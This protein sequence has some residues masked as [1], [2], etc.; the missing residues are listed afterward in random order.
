M[1]PPE[2]SRDEAPSSEPSE[3][4]CPVCLRNNVPEAPFCAMCGAPLGPVANIDPIQQIRSEGFAFRSAVSSPP[5]AL[6]LAGTWLAMLPLAGSAFGM[7]LSGFPMSLFGFAM[8]MLSVGVLVRA[9]AHFIS[10]KRAIARARKA[11]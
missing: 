3:V 8:L 6:I 11:S 4:V 2:E 10:R 7:I 5:R 1:Q 9:T